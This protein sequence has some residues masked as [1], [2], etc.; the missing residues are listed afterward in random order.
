MTASLI[1]ALLEAPYTHFDDITTYSTYQGGLFIGTLVAKVPSKVVVQRQE[2]GM[3]RR[4]TE[5]H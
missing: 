3:E 2:R 1:K 5:I 4:N